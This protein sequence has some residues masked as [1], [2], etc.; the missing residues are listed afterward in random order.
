MLVSNSASLSTP[1]MWLIIAGCV[2]S[3]LI[4]SSKNTGKPGDD[5]GSEE[6]TGGESSSAG[7]VYNQVNYNTPSYILAIHY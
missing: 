2:L 3:V 1:L 5:T 7:P 4:I 6:V